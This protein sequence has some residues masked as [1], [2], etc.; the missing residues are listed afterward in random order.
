MDMRNLVGLSCFVRNGL[1]DPELLDLEDWAGAFRPE[2]H[3]K[4]TKEQ[5]GF[6]E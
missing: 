1:D 6:T 5:E 3:E 4:E 2:T